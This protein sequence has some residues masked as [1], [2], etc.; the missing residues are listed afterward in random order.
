MVSELASL[1][2]FMR[3]VIGRGDTVIIEEPE[4]HLHPA[5]QTEMA[6]ALTRLVRGGV[7]VIVTTHSDWLLQEIGN[8]MREGELAE[9]A[10]E[11]LPAHALRPNDV[12]VW[13]F[14]RGGAG[15]G[16]SIQKRPFDLVEGVEP[17]DYEDVAEQLYIRSADLQNSLEEVPARRSRRS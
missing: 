2:L 11:T 10:G 7:R 5:A 16:S 9:R 17:P 6:K 13:L 8:A 3:S 14:K 1:V 12:G 4:A 15:A